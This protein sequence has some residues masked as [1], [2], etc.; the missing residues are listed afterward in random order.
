MFLFG[1]LIVASASLLI[2]LNG[3]RKAPEAYEDELG[4]HI[5]RERPRCSG[6]SILPRRSKKPEAD[7]RRLDLP[8]PVGVGHFK[9]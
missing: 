7:G 2:T 6:A 9:A 3:L 5:I 4:F 8:L 1:A